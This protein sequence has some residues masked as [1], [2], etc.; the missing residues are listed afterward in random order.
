M[1]YHYTSLVF[2]YSDVW[3]KDLSVGGVFLCV[4]IPMTIRDTGMHS[5][6]ALRI[7]ATQTFTSINTYGGPGHNI[8]CDL[9]NEHMS[10]L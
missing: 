6:E 5:V 1:L 3:I 9:H 2:A 7:H 10:M 4:I 8:P